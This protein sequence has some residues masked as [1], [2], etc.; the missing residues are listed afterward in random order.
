MFCNVLYCTA[1]CFAWC[2]VAMRWVVLCCIVLL[3]VTVLC[4]VVLCYIVR[5]NRLILTHECYYGNCALQQGS[6]HEAQSTSHPGPSCSGK[7]CSY[8]CVE[9]KTSYGNSERKTLREREKKHIKIYKPPVK[10]P[11]CIPVSKQEPC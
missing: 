4:C 5:R 11:A 7:G 2:C 8:S 10:L 9:C 3:C 6:I 1:L